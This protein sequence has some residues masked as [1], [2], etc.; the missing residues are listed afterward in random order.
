AV[1]D[2]ALALLAGR[3][4][5]RHHQGSPTLPGRGA[6]GQGQGAPARHDVVPTLARSSPVGAGRGVRTRRTTRAARTSR[7]THTAATTARS[8]GTPTPACATP[9]PESTGARLS[10]TMSPPTATPR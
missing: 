10:S 1:A 2:H 7:D 9:S 8:V 3:A 4:V 6:A 5:R